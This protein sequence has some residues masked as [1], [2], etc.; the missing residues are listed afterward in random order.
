M[1]II[2]LTGLI[3]IVAVNDEPSTWYP[4][5]SIISPIISFIPTFEYRF[6]FYQ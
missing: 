1:I 6:F 3:I 2:E 5:G 4:S